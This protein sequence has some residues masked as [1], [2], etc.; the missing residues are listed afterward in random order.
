MSGRAGIRGTCLVCKHPD[1]ARI[2]LMLARGAS[3]RAVGKTFSISPHSAWR[4]WTNGHVPD[5]VKSTLAIKALKP[6]AELAELITDESTGLLE[7][8]QRIRAVLYGAFDAAAECGDRVSV[9]SLSAR[10]HENLRIAATSTG[11]LQKH[12]RGNVTNILLAPAYLDLRGALL[13]ALR[14][15]PAASAAVSAAFRRVEAPL[16]EGRAAEARVVNA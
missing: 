10:L 15:Y 7:N 2:E 6:G 13:M 14:Q 16:L 11:E 3:R 8:L 9:A 1:R 12:A 4:H 5:H